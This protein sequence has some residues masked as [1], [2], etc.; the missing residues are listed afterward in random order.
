MP[1]KNNASIVRY[2]TAVLPSCQQFI[3]CRVQSPVI[4]H[5]AGRVAFWPQP[6]GSLPFAQNAWHCTSIIHNQNYC[7]D[8]SISKIVW[9]A[10]RYFD[11]GGNSHKKCQ[12]R[13]ALGLPYENVINSGFLRNNYRLRR[14]AS[15]VNQT[16]FFRKRACTWK[17]EGENT[18]WPGFS[19]SL[20]CYD[21]NV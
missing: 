4:K 5:T 10:V 13:R 9:K 7:A 11:G 21:V 18:V 20:G 8:C 16:V 2:T 14:M 12:R 3:E 15:L 17:A 6:V 19:N 1:R